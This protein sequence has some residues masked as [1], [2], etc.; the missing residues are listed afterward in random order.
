[1][2][3]LKFMLGARQRRATASDYSGDFRSLTRDAS[4][5]LDSEERRIFLIILL[6]V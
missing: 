2:R 6:F 3:I 5:S 4:L 1:M